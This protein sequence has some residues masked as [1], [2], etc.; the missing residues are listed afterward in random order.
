MNV[1]FFSPHYP[2]EMQDFVRGL[3]EVGARVIALG[4]APQEQ[5]PDHVRRHLSTYCRVAHL[6][7]GEGL[8]RELRS[9]LPGVEIDRVE[10]LWEPCVLAAAHLRE[11][12][13]VPGMRPDV[14]VGF[15]DKAVMKERLAQAGLR[16][17]RSARISTAREAREAAERIGYPLVIKPVSGAGSADTHRLAGPDDLDAVLPRLG[18]VPEASIEEYVAGDELT[19]DTVSIDGLPAFDSVS[20]YHPKPIEGRSQEWISPAQITFRD[21]HAEPALAAGIALGQDVLRT[22]GMG[23]GFTHMEWFRTPEGQAV[24]CEVAA[25]APGARLVDQMN[26]ANDFDVFREWARAVCWGAFGAAP[27]RAYHVGTVFKRARGQGRIRRI[28]GLEALRRRCGDGLI[29][30]DFLPIG[31]ERRDWRSTLISDGYAIVRHP[32]Y[33]RCREMMDWLVNDVQIYAA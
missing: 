2:R 27:S 3:S 26:F 9:A 7:D 21:P 6:F 31:A 30:E 28:E 13:D 25:R 33:A 16:V 18:H 8:A 11:V 4:D 23:T 20:Q 12:F 19:Y 15:R 5:I 14:A 22:L 29:V 10:A 32:D 1:L 24:F 17:P